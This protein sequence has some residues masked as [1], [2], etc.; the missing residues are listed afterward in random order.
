MYNA[1]FTPFM[2]RAPLPEPDPEDPLSVVES[3]FR[4]R[5]VQE[6]EWGSHP[7]VI[8]R[9]EGIHIGGVPEYAGVSLLTVNK[10]FIHG[11]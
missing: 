11:K 1:S 3:E 7:F 5:P 2:N 4:L 9:Q 8:D 6:R 10:D